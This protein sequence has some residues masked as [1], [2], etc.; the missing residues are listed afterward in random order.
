MEMPLDGELLGMYVIQS[1]LSNHAHLTSIPAVTNLGSAS[2]SQSNP[3]SPNPICVLSPHQSMLAH[4]MKS[5]FL[6]QPYS[7]GFDDDINNVGVTDICSHSSF[8]A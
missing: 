4:S 3:L 5:H 2:L 6:F 7:S 8:Q 1:V